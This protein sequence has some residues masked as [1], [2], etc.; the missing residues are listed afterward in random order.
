M[1]KIIFLFAGTLLSLNLAAQTFASFYSD[2][3]SGCSPLAVS[4]TNTSI[5]ATSYSWDFGDGSPLST[6]VNPTHTYTVSGTFIVQLTACGFGCNTTPSSITV[7][8]FPNVAITSLQSPF[9]ACNSGSTSMQDNSSISGGS[10][11]SWTWSPAG[12]LSCTNCQNTTATPSVTTVYTLTAAS[13]SGCYGSNTFTVFIPTTPSIAPLCLTTVDTTS[14]KNIVN[15]EKP[16]S[17]GN[18]DSF[19]IYR[20]FGPT[21]IV[22]LPYSHISSFTDT[23][24][25]VNPNVACYK[26]QLTYVTTSGVECA[27]SNPQKTMFLQVTQPSAPAFQLDWTEYFG[28]DYVGTYRIM[29]DG[30]NTGNFVKIDSVPCNTLTYTDPNPPTDSA[31]YYIETIT[32]QACNITF[33]QGGNN[34]VQGTVVKS[35]SNVKNNRATGINQFSTKKEQV[36]IFP[37]PNSGEFTITVKDLN[38]TKNMTVE[39]YNV[40]G[41]K[42]YNSNLNQ[43]DSHY[44]ISDLARGFYHI[45]VTMNG[46]VISGSKI[47]KQ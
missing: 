12:G 25:G 1:K 38:Q 13:N 24:S 33:R 15:W 43:P 20:D 35:R 17:Q 27:R 30:N 2:V 16:S 44:N 41:E 4:F 7:D 3:S 11:S 39:I 28:A 14:T 32:A 21:P 31:V 37:N 10:I 36:I 26:Y 46:K 45:R 9:T 18:I 22:T 34:S 6:A 8:P 40:L 42:I 29:R 19:K 23:T 5:G 47:I